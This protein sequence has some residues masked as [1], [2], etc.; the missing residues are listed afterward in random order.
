[1]VDIKSNQSN[2]IYKLHLNDEERDLI[3]SVTFQHFR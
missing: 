2:L 3:D 1:M